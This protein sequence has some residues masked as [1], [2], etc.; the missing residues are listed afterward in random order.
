MSNRTKSTLRAATNRKMLLCRIIAGAE[1]IF[2]KFE[3]KC[4]FIGISIAHA[5][6]V[7]TLINDAQLTSKSS[8]IIDLR[9]CSIFVVGVTVYLMG[10]FVFFFFKGLP[11]GALHIDQ[12]MARISVKNGIGEAPF[13]IEIRQVPQTALREYEFFGYGIP[14]DFYEENIPEIEAALNMLVAEIRDGRD[15]R[16]ITLVL[17]PPHS[18]DEA[19]RW[20]D[21]L[22]SGEDFVL[23]VG[24]S[25][26]GYEEI[27]LNLIPH[28]L[29]GG[30]TGSGKTVLLKNLLYQCY[31]K[32]AR[33]YVADFKGGI[34]FGYTWEQ[35]VHVDTTINDLIETLDSLVSQLN[36]RKVIFR[37]K[38]YDKLSTFNKDHPGELRR[39]IF[40]CDEIAELLDK[41]GLDKAEKEQ[42]IL[43][44]K[45]LST[46]ARQG[47]AFGIHLILATQR[48][49]A[50]ILSG[51]IRNNL[52]YRI[53]GRADDV[54]SKI[55]L[56]KTDA[57]ER[58]PKYERGL[59]LTNSDRLIRSF[60]FTDADIIPEMRAVTDHEN[61][62]YDQ[63]KA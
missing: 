55:V 19:E 38:G 42:V 2:S 35:L 57:S 12:E 50:T 20:N 15:R 17:A 39:I 26:L 49:D 56:D 58:I 34:D 29:I 33:V 11:K 4:M 22:I 60:F 27:D 28:I 32:N 48:P 52:D 45:A 30:S 43:V 46:I 62:I 13:L 47:R 7:I 63:S 53:C 36:E 9:Q 37:E 5:S 23:K 40:A 44:E 16:H 8:M 3:S 54:L 18:I 61:S 59:F 6:L 51:Q 31:C 25:V 14:R 24:K 10:T 41:A 21:Q 1:R